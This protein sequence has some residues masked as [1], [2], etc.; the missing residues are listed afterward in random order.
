MTNIRTYNPKL[1]LGLLSQTKKCLYSWFVSISFLMGIVLIQTSTLRA[2]QPGSFDL[3]FSGGQ[4]ITPIGNSNDVA[5]ALALQPDGKIVVAGASYNGLN[6]DFSLARYNS[7]GTLDTSFDGDGKIIIPIGNFSDEAHGVAIQSDGKIVVVGFSA[8]GSFEVFTLIRFNQNGTLDLSFGSG[9]IVKTRIGM[10]GSRALAVAIQPNGKIVVAGDTWGSFLDFAVVRYNLDGSLDRSFGS[11]GIVTTPITSGDDRAFAIA[12][13][14]DSKIVLAGD[15]FSLT[16]YNSDGSLDRRFGNNGIVT[17]TFGGT[18][19]SVAIQSDSKI[20]AAGTSSDHFT[21][22]RHNIDGSLDTSFGADGKVVTQLG[23]YDLLNGVAIQP[24]GKIVA[25]GYSSL[26]SSSDFALV[27]YNSNGSL[28]KNFG[29]V[30]KVL[31]RQYHIH[32]DSLRA[33]AI[34]NDGKIIGSGDSSL[35]NLPADFALVRYRTCL[36]LAY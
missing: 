36:Q 13:Q 18:A 21:L 6:Y 19:F 20:I 23:G 9:G 34:Q 11:D 10:S 14:P 2:A 30:G 32:Y 5:F 16:R 25:A 12:I 22:T 35:A 29:S 3:S 31:M 8:D 28:D 17:N 1:S 24:D 7:N 26:T 4:V 27:R 33:I 15:K